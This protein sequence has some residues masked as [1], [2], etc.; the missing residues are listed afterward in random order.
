MALFVSLL[1]S[2]VCFSEEGGNEETEDDRQL[3]DQAEL[4]TEISGSTREAREQTDQGAATSEQ[5]EEEE[6]DRG[7]LE[8]VVEPV[9]EDV[10]QEA[11][12]RGNLK[13]WRSC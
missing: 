12:E 1:S 5:P 11:D 13:H 9:G 3:Y 4:L 8:T 10:A 2:K 6:G 7:G